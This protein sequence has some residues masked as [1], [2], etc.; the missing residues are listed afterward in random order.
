MLLTNWTITFSWDNHSTQ[1]VKWIFYASGGLARTWVQ[2]NNNLANT[3]WTWWSLHIKWVVIGAWLDNLMQ[4]SRS[5]LNGWFRT[6]LPNTE[7]QKM[8]M[9]GASVLI[10]YSPSIFSKST[11]APGAE[12]F[13]TALSVYKN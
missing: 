13:T 1:T 3:R 5:N 4:Y 12:D 8:I 7:R 2:K 6:D 11:M 9:D 10:E